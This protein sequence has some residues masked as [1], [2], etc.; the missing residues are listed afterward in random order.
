MHYGN[1]HK[2]KCSSSYSIIARAEHLLQSLIFVY[3]STLNQTL[4]LQ[5]RK[6]IFILYVFINS[7]L[8]MLTKHVIEGD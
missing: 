5:K 4:L 2:C 7:A 3:L 1:L 6:T 8:Q